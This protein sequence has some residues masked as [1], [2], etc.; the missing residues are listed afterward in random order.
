MVAAV[1]MCAAVIAG[2][3]KGKAG[4]GSGSVAASGSGSVT[5]TGSGSVTGTGSGSATGSGSDSASGSGSAVLAPTNPGGM[6]AA[7]NDYKAV[8]DKLASCDKLDASTRDALRQAYAQLSAGWASLP[9]E[10]KPGVA[11]TCKTALEA[12][13][14]A[15]KSACGW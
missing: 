15:A 6:P 7:C 2:G 8:I 9:P 1:V 14:R 11:A 12:A 10:A 3:C 4:S 13:T 5:G